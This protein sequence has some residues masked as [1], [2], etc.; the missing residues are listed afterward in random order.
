M[1]TNCDS[2]T[3]WTTSKTVEVSA[4]GKATHP[5]I[6]VDESGIAYVA[7]ADEVGNSVDRIRMSHLC[8]NGASFVATDGGLV[9]N[10]NSDLG[11]EE[12]FSTRDADVV[13]NAGQPSPIIAIDDT[14][15][16]VGVS[17]VLFDASA[18]D[19]SAQASFTAYPTCP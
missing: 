14:D 8:P 10:R 12:A 3:E 11:D 17:Y 5:Q 13:N 1:S 19:W 4:N 16:K 9:D 6:T 15:N 2:E 18:D 7:Y